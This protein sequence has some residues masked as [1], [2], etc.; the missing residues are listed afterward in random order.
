MPNQA[1]VR[2]R[3][4]L[5]VNQC[6][7][8]IEDMN[9]YPG[10]CAMGSFLHPCDH[11]QRR[12]QVL[13]LRRSSS[14]RPRKCIRFG[15][16]LL[17]H[18]HYVRTRQCTAPAADRLRRNSRWRDPNFEPVVFTEPTIPGI[19][20]GAGLVEIVKP[21]LAR[22]ASPGTGHSNG[23]GTCPMTIPG[24]FSRSRKGATTLPLTISPLG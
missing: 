7:L 4:R 24:G 20:T 11:H 19:T 15:S 12:L 9:I 1:S 18:A 16:M 17:Q 23:T 5:S 14:F 8:A 6:V 13:A 3:Q 10:V 2:Q 22:V 21:D